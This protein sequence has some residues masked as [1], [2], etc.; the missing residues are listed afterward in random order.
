MSVISISWCFQTAAR[1]VKEFQSPWSQDSMDVFLARSWSTLSFSWWD[2]W[3][4]FCLRSGPLE[5]DLTEVCVQEIS[6]GALSGKKKKQ[7]SKEV[8]EGGLSRRI[9][10]TLMQLQEVTHM[11]RCS[12]PVISSW[13]KGGVGMGLWTPALPG[14]WM[15]RSHNIEPQH[16]LAEGSFWRGIHLWAISSQHSWQL[17][18]WV[19]CSRRR[20]WLT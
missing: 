9:C 17:G 7:N 13:G 8:T 15:E 10:W 2:Y 5:T 16:P 3:G 19:P 14:G 20:F 6:W 18:K 11:L 4:S 12:Y 1:I